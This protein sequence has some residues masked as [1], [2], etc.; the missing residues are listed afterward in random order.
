MARKHPKRR[1]NPGKTHRRRSGGDPTAPNWLYG[2]HAV[3]AALANPERVC[4]LARPLE[5]HGIEDA[6]DRALQSDTPC[7]LLL[8]QVTDPQNVGA[9]LRS[10]A[11]FGAAA[12][13]MQDRHAP[14]VTGALAKAASGGL[15]A[16]ALVRETNLSRS[17]EALKARNFWCIGLAGE[18]ETTLAQA[19]VTGPTALVLGAE[20][21]GLRRLVAESCDTLAHIP[22]SDAVESLNVSNAAAIALYE[23]ARQA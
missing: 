14:P 8:D 13:V 2:T 5:D 23:I 1:I 9:I 7:I 3:L 21:A 11:A 15:E 6:M 22:H 16:V 20:G 10:A 12:V 17:I 19:R 18:V 4:E